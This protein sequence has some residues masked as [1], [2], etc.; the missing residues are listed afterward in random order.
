MSTLMELKAQTQRMDDQGR[1]VIP[2]DVCSQMKWDTE[3]DLKIFVNVYANRYGL[4]S[5][6]VTEMSPICSICGGQAKIDALIQYEHA[7]LCATC[8]AKIKK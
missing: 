1:V 2:P 8:W 3:T 6:T 5:I 4:K 7:Y